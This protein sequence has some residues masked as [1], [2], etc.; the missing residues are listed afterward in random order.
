MPGAEEEE[1]RLREREK[2]RRGLERRERSRDQCDTGWPEA[3][4]TNP[5]EPDQKEEGD[6][7]KRTEKETVAWLFSS[8]F[9]VPPFKTVV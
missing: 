8:S 2:G 3:S 7:E 6:E 9:A 5:L 4:K 1:E